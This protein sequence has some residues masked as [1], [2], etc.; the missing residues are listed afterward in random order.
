MKVSRILIVILFFILIPSN[1]IGSDKYNRSVWGR[2]NSNTR[3][4]V[5]DNYHVDMV[6]DY[7]SGWPIPVSACQLEHIIPVAVAWR[8]GG[9]KW[10]REQRQQFYNDTDNLV[11]TTGGTNASKGD[12]TPLQWLPDVHKEEYIARWRKG[13]DKYQ[14]NCDEVLP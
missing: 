6:L 11:C 10:T 7:Y 1:C 2:F 8:L 3:P 12:K 14:L 9:Y 13:C 5:I 4:I